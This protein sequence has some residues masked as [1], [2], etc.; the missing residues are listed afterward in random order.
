MVEAVEGR[1]VEEE[2]GG[3]PVSA[4]SPLHYHR[5]RPGRPPRGRPNPPA[6]TLSCCGRT[7][8]SLPRSASSSRFP[9]P[10]PAG[11]AW[12]RP[13]RMLPGQE[14]RGDPQGVV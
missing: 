13:P 10:W 2:K 14:G 12:G 4:S 11:A 9:P 3:R 5:V 1:Q 7:A 8:P 6:R